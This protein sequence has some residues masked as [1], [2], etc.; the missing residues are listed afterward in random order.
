VRVNAQAAENT[1]QFPGSLT[2]EQFHFHPRRASE[3]KNF[4]HYQTQVFQLLNKHELNSKWMLETRLAHNVIMGD[5]WIAYGFNRKEWQDSINPQLVTSLWNAKTV[6]GYF[7]Q[8]TEYHLATKFS[9]Q[10]ATA[11]QN[12]IY[13]QTIIPVWEKIDVTLGT[14]S[15]WQQNSVDGLIEVEGPIRSTNH[16]FVSEQGI[17]YRPSREWQFFL[18]RDGNFRFPKANEETWLKPGENTLKPQTG[19]SYETGLVRKTDQQKTQ[20]N[21]Y[22]LQLQNEI[23]FDPTETPLEPMG[24]YNNFPTT[25]RRGATIAESYYMTRKLK[26]DSQL[27]FVD[28]RFS[29]G[30]FS[31]KRIPTV[32]M[33][34][35]NAGARYEFTENW[36]AKFSALYTGSRYASLDLANQHKKMSG[37]WLETVALQY[38]RP[39]YEVSFEVGNIFNAN[40]AAFAVYNKMKHKNL[41]YPGTGRSYLLTFKAS[42]D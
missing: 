40:Y 20:F 11:A 5:G 7:G 38:M 19:V 31:G 37:Y 39:S 41:Y 1:V 22:H 2:E 30:L 23:A 36:R 15:A 17:S 10:K 26:L 21:L 12:D 4:S 33:F 27:N 8:R 18:R 34:N 14:R 42:I 32:P 24:R 9:Q 13:A 16:V 6:L 25:L 29:S 3:F 28:A 35:A